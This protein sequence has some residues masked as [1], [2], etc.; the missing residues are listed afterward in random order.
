MQQLIDIRLR[1]P[2]EVGKSLYTQLAPQVEK[3]TKTLKNKVKQTKAVK[4]EW[5]ELRKYGEM[6]VKK[7]G[8]TE[9]DVLEDT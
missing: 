2:F 4:D 1:V 6:I 7:Y 8:F 9:A 5:E 3:E